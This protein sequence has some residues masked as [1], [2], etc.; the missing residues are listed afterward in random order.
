MKYLIQREYNSQWKCWKKML[1]V[2]Y[3]MFKTFHLATC[4]SLMIP[5]ANKKKQLSISSCFEECIGYSKKN[6]G[7]HILIQA[8]WRVCQLP[9][10][11]QE[12][13]SWVQK[14]PRAHSWRRKR[15]REHRVA[16]QSVLLQN[17]SAWAQP[18][19][20]TAIQCAAT[21]KFNIFVKMFIFAIN[22]NLF[23]KIYSSRAK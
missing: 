4:L 13:A 5:A 12:R 21:E 16:R 11:A 9:W 23:I 1:I 20:R 10:T 2:L 6:S 14:M 3:I 22:C 19:T 17:I 15:P 18:N 7:K 8:C